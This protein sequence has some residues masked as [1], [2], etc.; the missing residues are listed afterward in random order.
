MLC[1]C[2]CVCD[3]VP[4]PGN[5]VEETDTDVYNDIEGELETSCLSEIEGDGGTLTT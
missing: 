3:S 4:D 5:T 1:V 2:V